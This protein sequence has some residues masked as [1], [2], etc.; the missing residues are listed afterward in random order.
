MAEPDITIPP[1]ALEAAV[2]AALDAEPH[3][4]DQ[5]HAAC[6]AMLRNWPGGHQA[7]AVDGSQHF[8]LPLTKENV[9]GA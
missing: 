3:I 9:D 8:M 5:L 7:N 2:A 6:I 4:R 1:E